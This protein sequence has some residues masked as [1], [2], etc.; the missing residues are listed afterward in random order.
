M[1][2][3]NVMSLMNRSGSV[4]DMRSNCLLLDDGLDMLVDMVVDML[5]RDDGTS[6][7]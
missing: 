1:D 2:G 4:H 6:G 3:L 5:A 7:G